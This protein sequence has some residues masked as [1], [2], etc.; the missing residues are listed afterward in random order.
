MRAARHPA[1]DPSGN[2]RA[3][4]IRRETAGFSVARTS[5]DTR[6]L[7]PFLDLGARQHGQGAIS[8]P[9]LSAYREAAFYAGGWQQASR[10]AARIG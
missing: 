3:F 10:N 9:S 5:A 1:L 8:R 6:R 4:S 2:T 7:W